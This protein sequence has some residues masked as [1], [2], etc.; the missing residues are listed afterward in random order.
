[1]FFSLKYCRL[2]VRMFLKEGFY[3]P[4]HCVENANPF[5]VLI[6]NEREISEDY[7]LLKNQTKHNGM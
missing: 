4:H 6:I 3:S 7:I 5:F 2:G 1:M